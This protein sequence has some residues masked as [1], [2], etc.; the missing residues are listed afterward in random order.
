MYIAFAIAVIIAY[1]CFLTSFFERYEFNYMRYLIYY[2][3]HH[4]DQKVHW[5]LLGVENFTW[6]QPQRPL[7]RDAVERTF[8]FAILYLVMN[9]LLIVASLIA[10]CKFNEKNF[11]NDFKS[12]HSSWGRPHCQTAP[13]ILVDVLHAFHSDLHIHICFR[14]HSSSVL[15]IWFCEHSCKLFFAKWSKI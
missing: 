15:R 1:N 2:Q 7:Q 4:C 9:S 14:H 12:L 6:I 5:E 11:W 3:S 13:K 8:I 10:F